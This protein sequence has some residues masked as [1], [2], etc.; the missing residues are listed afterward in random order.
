MRRHRFFFADILGFPAF[1]TVNGVTGPDAFFQSQFASLYAWSSI[2]RSNYNAGQF[3][4]RHQV[5]HGLTWNFNYTYSRSIDI[6][7][8]A[9]R[10][11]LFEGFGFASQVIN[12]FSPGQLRG[13]SDFDTTHQLNTSWVYELPVGAR[14]EIW[15]Q[16]ESRFR[17][18]SRRLGMVGGWRGGLAVSPSVWAMAL[19][20]QPT[21]S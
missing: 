16:L 19:I 17:R 12:A 8:N 6:G 10:V 18:C 4:L 7:S 5:T 15:L 11:S 13:V 20:S 2:G 21:G 1:P 14:Q 3:S 9:E